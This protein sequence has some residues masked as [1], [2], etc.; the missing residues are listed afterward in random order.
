MAGEIVY[1]DLIIPSEPHSSRLIHP[2]QQLNASQCPSWHRIT[3][4]AGCIGIVIL[5]AAVIAMGLLLKAET[6][7]SR[8]DADVLSLLRSVLCN[9]T[10][11]NASVSSACKICPP[12]WHHYRGKCYWPS[13]Q[14]KSWKESRDHCSG[15]NSQLLVIQDKEEMEFIP[16]IIEDKSM[17][18]IGLAREEIPDK[19]WLWISGSEFDQTLFQEPSRTGRNNCGAI[20][21]RKIVSDNCNAELSGI[22][23]RDSISI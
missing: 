20:K 18:W 5:V 1:A 21:N 8:T 10:L 15:R 19:K 7:K 4:W 17:Y 3:L 22:C 9:Q 12:H 16:E 6:E 23:Q 11:G 14:H 2:P 13:T